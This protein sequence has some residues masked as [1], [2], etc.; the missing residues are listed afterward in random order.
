[1][2][3]AA[4]LLGCALALAACGKKAPPQPP[5]PSDQVTWPHKYPTPPG[6]S[7]KSETSKP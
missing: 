1:M 7:I 4:L 2:K 6:D 5:G 3:T